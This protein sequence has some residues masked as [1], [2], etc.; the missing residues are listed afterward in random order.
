MDVTVWIELIAFIILMGLSA[1][2]PSSETALFS[3]NSVQLEQMRQ[4]NH[5]RINLITNMLISEWFIT[6][7]V[8][9]ERSRGNIITEDLVRTVAYEAV[10][11]GTLDRS[12]VQPI[13]QIFEFGNK[14]L[15][16]VRRETILPWQDSC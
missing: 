8:G 12:E 3:L 7:I 4:S 13:D 5:P 6:R 1:F 9:K 16:G 11:E 14:T 10:G 2:F 15:E